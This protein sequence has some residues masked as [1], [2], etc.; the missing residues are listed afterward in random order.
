MKSH[1]LRRVTDREALDAKLARSAQKG[2]EAAF[3]ELFNTYKSQVY[4]LCLGATHNSAEAEELTLKAFLQVFRRLSIS[5]GELAVSDWLFQI[6]ATTV[7]L[8]SRKS[9]LQRPPISDALLDPLAARLNLEAAGGG[10][11]PVSV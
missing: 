10:G 11:V 1:N 6:A 2:E 5:R 8:H 3:A 4:A 7:V 9:K